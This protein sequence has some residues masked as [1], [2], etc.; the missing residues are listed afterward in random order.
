MP[1]VDTRH[2]EKNHLFSLY[3]ALLTGDIEAQTDRLEATM[4]KEDVQQVLQK[5]EKRRQKSNQN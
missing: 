3:E 1:T 4:E 5:V 2:A